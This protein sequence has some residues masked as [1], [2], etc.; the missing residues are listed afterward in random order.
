MKNICPSRVIINDAV[1]G[2]VL[3]VVILN[4]SPVIFIFHAT[5]I[6]ENVYVHSL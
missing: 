2:A 5:S 4:L 1:Y 6:L 3:T